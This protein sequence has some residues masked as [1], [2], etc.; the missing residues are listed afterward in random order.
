MGNIT[1]SFGQIYSLGT[2]EWA[3]PSNFLIGVPTAEDSLSPESGE[4]GMSKPREKGGE[5]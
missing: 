2:D 4:L 1:C 5:S 3:C